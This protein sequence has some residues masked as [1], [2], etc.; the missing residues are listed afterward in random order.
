MK[1]MLK[2][3]LRTILSALAP[4]AII[5]WFLALGPLSFLVLLFAAYGI[6]TENTGI[7]VLMVIFVLLPVV[8]VLLWAL[9]TLMTALKEGWV[10]KAILETGHDW[11][12]VRTELRILYQSYFS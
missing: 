7:I 3:I 9:S 5:I 1:Q 8:L 11:W 6:A 4:T 10:Q 12:S 2:K